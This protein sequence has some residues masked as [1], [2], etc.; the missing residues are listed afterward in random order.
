MYLG[1]NVVTCAGAA[2]AT[3]IRQVG[4]WGLYRG[5]K[6]GVTGAAY[7]GQGGCVGD[8]SSHTKKFPGLGQDF[9]GRR[10]PGLDWLGRG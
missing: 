8:C 9:T 7:S 4:Q 5:G 1:K 6:Q 2:I 3:V 10:P